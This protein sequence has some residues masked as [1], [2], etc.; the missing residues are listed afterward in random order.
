MSTPI[1]KNAFLILR[2]MTEQPRDK[3][4]FPNLTGDEL[5]KLTGLNPDQI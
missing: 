5:S 3:V 1:E 4:D 2:T